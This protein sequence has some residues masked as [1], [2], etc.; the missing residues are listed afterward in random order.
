MLETAREIRRS[1]TQAWI[2][3]QLWPFEIES[4]PGVVER[5]PGAGITYFRE[6]RAVRS[7]RVAEVLDDLRVLIQRLENGPIPSRWQRA[8]AR[9]HVGA[10]NSRLD[11][12]LRVYV[13]VALERGR[14]PVRVGERSSFYISWLPDTTQRPTPRRP[15][16][17]TGIYIVVPDPENAPLNYYRFFRDRQAPGFDI[18]NLFEVRRDG[19]G[20][21][22][23]RLGRRID[24]P[25]AP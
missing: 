9:I 21:F 5:S 15:A 3:G 13:H 8:P 24:L 10:S 18:R 20:Y 11:A 22:Y 25:E 14:D 6:S 1:M 7:A 19:Q 4:T 12:L 23:I 2:R 17:G 16:Y